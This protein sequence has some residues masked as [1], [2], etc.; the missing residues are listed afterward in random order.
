MA[1]AVKANR[2]SSAKQITRIQCTGPTK[3]TL[4]TPLESTTEATDNL[5]D[6]TYAAQTA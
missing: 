5:G 2:R 4:Y 6:F 1:F 3:S